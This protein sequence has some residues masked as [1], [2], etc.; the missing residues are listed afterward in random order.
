[1]ESTSSSCFHLQSVHHNS[2]QLWRLPSWRRPQPA[3]PKASL[4]QSRN[5]SV[6]LRVAFWPKEPA[7]TLRMPLNMRT[8]SSAI[9]F[10]RPSKKSMS[11]IRTKKKMF[12]SPTSR[13]QQVKTRLRMSGTTTE[14]TLAVHSTLLPPTTSSG[15]LSRKLRNYSKTVQ[16]PL[17]LLLQAHLWSSWIANKWRL[18]IN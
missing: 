10:T 14:K 18:S 1:M 12:M 13:R 3:S 2:D 16:W 17:N 5:P 11:F 15:R 8:R 9:C 6:K 7:E 4:F